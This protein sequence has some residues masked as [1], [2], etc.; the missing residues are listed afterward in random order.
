[1]AEAEEDYDQEWR[2]KKGPYL[3]DVS[4]LCFVHCPWKSS[5]PYLLA[6]TG[7]QLFLYDIET[8]E[9]LCSSHVFDGIRVHGIH[10]SCYVVQ[11]IDHSCS[12]RISAVTVAVFGE[13][14][15]KLFKLQLTEK[16]ECAKKPKEQISLDLVQVLPTFSHWVMD[17]RFLK[18]ACHWP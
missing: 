6:G 3:G 9:L 14:R 10:S 11:D 15:V 16:S 12:M 7:A 1:M 17:V 2:V 13:R 5:V 18:F 8:G 4:A